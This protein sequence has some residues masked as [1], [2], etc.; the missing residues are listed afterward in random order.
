VALRSFKLIAGVL[1]AAT[2]LVPGAADAQYYG[3]GSSYSY[4]GYGRPG[5]YRRDDGYARRGYG[6]AYDDRGYYARRG[7]YGRC[8]HGSG[9]TILGA[10]AGGLLGTAVAG[11]RDQALGAIAGAGAGALIGNAADRGC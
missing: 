3:A 9:G 6:R 4:G 11:R 5:D 1:A 7:Y 2:L 8:R 10:V